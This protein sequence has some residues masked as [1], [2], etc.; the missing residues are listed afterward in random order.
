MQYFSLD[1][2]SF[3]A[4]KWIKDVS[5]L[6]LLHYLSVI[7]LFRITIVSYLLKSDDTVQHT[8]KKN[9]GFVISN[10]FSYVVVG[11]TCPAF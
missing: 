7:L 4:P 10:I 9:T 8:E 5:L 3:Q 2:Y 11:Q 1:E 6:S